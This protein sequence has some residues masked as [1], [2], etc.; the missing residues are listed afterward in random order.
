[1]RHLTTSYSNHYDALSIIV[2]CTQAQQV[3]LVY[4]D[5]LDPQ[6][7]LEHLVHQVQREI[8]EEMDPLDPLDH[9]LVLSPSYYITITDLCGSIATAAVTNNICI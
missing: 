1:M 3:L 6:G 9:L 8:L 4:L 5:H 7:P 2:V